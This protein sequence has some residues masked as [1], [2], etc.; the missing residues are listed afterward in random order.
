MEDRLKDREG[1][2]YLTEDKTKPTILEKR[3]EEKPVRCLSCAR[4]DVS[5]LLK[6]SIGQYREG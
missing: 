4:M 1:M 5:G 3:R 6:R 2:K